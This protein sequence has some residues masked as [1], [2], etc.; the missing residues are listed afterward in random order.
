MRV[1]QCDILLCGVGEC[2]EPLCLTE[3]GQEG[4]TTA[5][6]GSQ[7]EDEEHRM[8]ASTTVFVV[9]PGLTALGKSSGKIRSMISTFLNK[10]AGQPINIY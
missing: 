1:L 6:G 8:M 4:G 10:Q 9:E 7:A 3:P 5:L 2:G